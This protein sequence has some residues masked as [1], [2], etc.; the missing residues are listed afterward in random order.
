M[1]QRKIALPALCLVLTT[2]CVNL[3][4][5]S[6]S[7]N[8]INA[9][10]QIVQTRPSYSFLQILE[11]SIL[12]IGAVIVLLA[13][14]CLITWVPKIS[15]YLV[16]RWFNN[17]LPPQ[18]VTGF[19]APSREQVADTIVHSDLVAGVVHE[20]KTSLMEKNM[21]IPPSCG[22]VRSCAPCCRKCVPPKVGFVQWLWTPWVTSELQYIERAGMDGYLL[23]RTM[24]LLLIFA[25][26][27]VVVVLS[28]LVPT[29]YLLSIPCNLT[30]PSTGFFT[31]LSA[32][33][34]TEEAGVICSC[35]IVSQVALSGGED[36]HDQQA[37]AVVVQA[38]LSAAF[39]FLLSREFEYWM[40]VRR[41]YC[42]TAPPEIYSVMVRFI[43]AYLRSEGRLRQFFED[44]YP[45]MVH[46]VN[47]CPVDKT[48]LGAAGH[49]PA[50]EH[51][52]Y[53]IAR[54]EAINGIYRNLETNKN[55]RC[56]RCRDPSHSMQQLRTKEE[57]VLRAIE[58]AHTSFYEAA[59]EI[60]GMEPAAEHAYHL[61]SVAD[62]FSTDDV[63]W[64]HHRYAAEQERKAQF[65][66][67]SKSR[68]SK[69]SKSESR[70]KTPSARHRTTGA[71]SINAD[72]ENASAHEDFND[73][74]SNAA[75]STEAVDIFSCNAFVTFKSAVV[76]FSCA[77][78]T[79]VAAASQM[80]LVPAR[81]PRDVR[82]EKLNKHVPGGSGPVNSTIGVLY[83]LILIT[84]GGVVFIVGN[85]T[86][87]QTLEYVCGCTG[88]F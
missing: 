52:R 79:V 31:D 5:A 62:V 69:A 45:G 19:S 38:V 57:E 18:L 42:E 17:E 78:D 15:R 56:K 14:Y 53:Q 27:T 47:F 65:R 34:V 83:F 68:K 54:E 41:A 66:M 44:L 46:S 7:D 6:D 80:K 37:A 72:I 76:A 26:L 67:Q 60:A 55:I 16:P 81:Q 87:Q 21:S 84:W 70:S 4:G 9:T 13:V 12:Y 20:V 48:G 61:P 75:H 88:C 24:R 32:C 74:H 8:S 63:P 1:P 43:P 29:Y 40:K 30:S 71:F 58:K 36:V 23:F 51:V 59:A 10:T 3:C 73:A 2:T 22:E 50:L 85:L 82:W 35:G 49:V 28:V 77:R 25:S 33:N 39:L 86:S 64:S 11:N